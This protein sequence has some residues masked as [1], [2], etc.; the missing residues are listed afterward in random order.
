MALGY[1]MFLHFGPNTFTQSGWGDGRFPAGEF[2]P[3]AL[4]PEQWAAVAVEAGMRY[5][6]LTAKHHDGFCLWPSDHTDYCVTHSPG[7]PDVVGRYAAAF[8][9]AGL[10]VGLYYSL[11]DRHSPHYEDDAAYAGYMRHQLTELL[12]R[13]GEIVELWFDGGWD[14]DHPTREWPFTPA[15]ETDPASGLHHGERWEWPAL[16]AHI[17]ALQPDC[18]VVKNSSS[19]WPGA[20]RYHPVDVR[21]SEH[22][23][24]IWEDEVRTPMVDPI[25]TDAAGQPLYLPLEFCTSLNPHWFWLAGSAYSHPASATICDWYRTARRVGANLLLNVGPNRDGRLPDY[26][27]RYLA[28]AACELGLT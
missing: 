3:A 15:W 7:A 10:R 17:H 28:D 20:V 13:Y 26:H 14:K 22:F 18:L 2:A 5:A 24:F 1:G 27:R 6:V 23:H 11:W 9:R 12:T 8:R 4:D 21:T 19:D 25:T 16:Y